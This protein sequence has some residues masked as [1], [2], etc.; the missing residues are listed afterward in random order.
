MS[1]HDDHEDLKASTTPGY[2]PTAAKTA[3]EYARLDAEDESLARWKASLGITGGGSA[4]ATGPKVTVL[5][6]ELHSDTLPPGKTIV[7]DLKDGKETVQNTKKEPIV[8]KEGVEYN[9][10]IHFRVNHSIISGV[11][12]LQVVKRSGIKVDKLEQMLGS[13]GPSPDE[14]PYTKN[15]EPEESPSGML[16]RSGTY[17]VKS[18]VQDDD[19]EIYADFSWH[20]KLAKEW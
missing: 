18:R 10:R 2:K 5:S 15:F 11:R 16:A 8:I 13:Y 17:D 9:V 4:P 12:Y 6:L 19:G 14:K 20:F 1:T 3:E 7:L